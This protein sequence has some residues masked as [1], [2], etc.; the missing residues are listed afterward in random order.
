MG[1]RRV[2]RDLQYSVYSSNATGS[3]CVCIGV[4]EILLFSMHIILESFLKIGVRTPFWTPFPIILEM[5]SATAKYKPGVIIISGQKISMTQSPPAMKTWI[6]YLPS[7]NCS[8]LIWE[9]GGCALL[10]SKCGREYWVMSGTVEAHHIRGQRV[11]WKSSAN[12]VPL[13]IP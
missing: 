8:L 7:G 4:C 13:K 2:L 1:S 9:Q 12:K 10:A 11:M 5:I 6:S 3:V